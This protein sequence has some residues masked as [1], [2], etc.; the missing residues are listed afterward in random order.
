MYTPISRDDLEHEKMLWLVQTGQGCRDFVKWS[1][2]CDTDGDMRT[3]IFISLVRNSDFYNDDF[4]K[5]I[6]FSGVQDTSDTQWMTVIS[7]MDSLDGETQA[8]INDHA[9]KCAKFFLDAE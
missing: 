6:A 8:I 7:E 2:G 5:D 1:V 4:L 3:D 9:E